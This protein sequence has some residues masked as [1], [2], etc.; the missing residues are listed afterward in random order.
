MEIAPLQSLTQVPLRH[1]GGVGFD[2]HS[3]VVTQEEEDEMT[4][5]I[6]WEGYSTIPV[7]VSP[8]W[9]HDDGSVVCKDCTPLHKF[10]ALL[11]AEGEMLETPCNCCNQRIGNI[12]VRTHART[13]PRRFACKI[14]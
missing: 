3:G 9:K 4:E 8:Y 1:S 14:F 7:V 6:E 13:T 12:K 10:T 2:S 5:I 11:H